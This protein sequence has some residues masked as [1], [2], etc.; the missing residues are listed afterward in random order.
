M[1]PD[2]SEIILP[3]A[4]TTLGFLIALFSTHSNGLLAAKQV[5]YS[6]LIWFTGLLMIAFAGWFIN[7]AFLFASVYVSFT[8]FSLLLLGRKF[9]PTLLSPITN[10]YLIVGLLNRP[11]EISSNFSNLIK[12][13]CLIVFA[14]LFGISCGIAYRAI[15]KSHEADMLVYTAFI[16]SFGF[17]FAILWFAS[18]RRI[19][20]TLS[21]CTIII[22]INILIFLGAKFTGAP[23]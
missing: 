12:V 16:S 11:K 5:L 17:A 19:I 3:I 23:L 10:T 20:R 4:A 2:N 7:L 22:G 13:L 1:K 8:A 18:S 9:N 15:G 6:R 14:P 21:L